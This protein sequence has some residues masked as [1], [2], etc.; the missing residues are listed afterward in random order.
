MADIQSISIIGTG[1]VAWHL[2]HAL[3]NAGFNILDV[4][5]RTASIVAEYAEAFNA[6]PQLQINQMDTQVDLILICITDDHIAEVEARIPDFEGIIA[7]TSGA[8][9]MNKTRANCGVF[10]P[11]QTFSKTVLV[12][13]ESVPVLI[14]GQTERMT[15]NLRQVA[16]RITSSVFQ[17][18]SDQ[19]ERL[20][21]AAVFVNNFSN[22]MFVQAYNICQKNN[23]PFGVLQALILE[24]ANKAMVGNPK[25][26]QTGPA[27]R[28]DLKTIAK[29]L[30]LLTD[31]EQRKL[32]R[33]ITDSILKQHETEL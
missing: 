30:G 15:A 23:I 33:T 9:R 21:V 25:E 8:E 26:A 10:Y 29:H 13:F 3:K 16:Q 17:V 6:K 12:N 28:H 4:M 18:N 7:H 1:N 24:T 22:H 31:V 20:H 27:Q 19:R 2:G 32:Y 5:G 11:L 14:E